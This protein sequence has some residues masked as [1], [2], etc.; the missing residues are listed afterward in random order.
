MVYLI[1][2]ECIEILMIVGYGG[3]Q[4]TKQEVLNIFNQL[5]LDRPPI[6]QSTDSR[7]ILKFNETGSIDDRRRHRSQKIRLKMFY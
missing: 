6:T 7:I 2:K 5:H 3:C 4:K 1:S